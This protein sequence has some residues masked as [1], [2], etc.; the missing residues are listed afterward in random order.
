MQ[1]R[2]SRQQIESYLPTLIAG[3][4]VS[5]FTFCFIF[6][7]VRQERFIYFYDSYTYFGFYQDLGTRIWHTPL[8]ALDSIFVSIR[9][10]DYNLSGIV[11]LMPFR[12]I[13]GGGR[14]A[15]ISAVGFTYA[16]PTILF[17]PFVV[18]RV[19]GF[20]PDSRLLDRFGRMIVCVLTIMLLPQ[21]WL[22]I[23]NGYVDVAGVGLI[24]LIFYLSIR[25]DIAELKLRQLLTMGILLS[26]LIVF[27]RWYAYWVVGFF[28]AV[29][30]VE[31][32]RAVMHQHS[33]QRLL[34]AAKNT[35]IIGTT[36]VVFFFAF[37]SK[38]AIRMLTSDYRELYSAFRSNDSI[39]GYLR[40][41]VDYFGFFMICLVVLGLIVGLVSAKMRRPVV[42]LFVL[43]IATFLLFTRTQD[44]GV[45]HYYWVMSILIIFAG[46]FV[47]S[48][49]SRLKSPLFK[50]IFVIAL[51]A[52]GFANFSIVFSRQAKA[53]LGPV[54]PVLSRVEFFPIVR[55]DLDQIHSLL[56]ALNDLPTVSSGKIYVLSSSLTLNYGIA[57]VGCSSFEPELPALR[58]RIMASNDVDLRDGFPFQIYQADYV[59]VTD[60]PGYHLRIQDQQVVVLLARQFLTGASVAHSYTR[61][62]FE[63]S[64][65]D[66]RKVSIYKKVRAYSP[67][68]LKAVSD[69]F[70]ELYP[71]HREKFE[72]TPEMM[73]GLTQP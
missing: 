67:D 32:A 70:V 64:L 73:A 35:A 26:L 58:K 72:I 27:R 25:K 24:F 20:D 69:M 41:L 34:R 61:L 21:F 16:L 36:S 38:V 71:N 63:V 48:L 51:V 6:W 8:K 57:I 5:A 23:V 17:F 49:Y 12:A 22:P 44:I 31:L 9:K 11:P 13:F 15:F 43:F 14:L 47:T 45:Q 40:A 54:D 55:N 19:A 65:G 28:V 10:S 37:A 60:P 3:L 33:F 1:T 52:I 53:K 39:L 29:A 46:I 66:G 4:M 56:T 68:D 62:P 7:F 50:T 2:L 18:T 30:V 59:V 42:F